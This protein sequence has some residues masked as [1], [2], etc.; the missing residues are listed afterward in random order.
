MK[1]SKKLLWV[2]FVFLVL[3]VI[4]RLSMPSLINYGIVDWFE[5]QGIIA[6]VEKVHI[7]LSN[8]D[9][10][11]T[12][13]TGNK[14][15]EQVLKLEE[16]SISWFW[17]TL[18][19]S[20]AKFRSIKLDG[21]AFDIE[22]KEN[23]NLIVA[24]LDINQLSKSS[25]ETETT[26]ADEDNEPVDWRVILEELKLTD[27]DICYRQ[28]DQ[29]YCNHF[30]KLNW[31]GE[32][33][34]DLSKLDDPALP[35]YA[36]GSFTI[37]ALQVHDNIL[38]RDLANFEQ[39]SIEGI[40]IDSFNSLGLADLNLSDFNFC[41]KQLEQDHCG[42]FDKLGW[43]GNLTVDL[44]NLDGTPP[45]INA[46]GGFGID[47]LKVH[48]NV[49]DRDLAS[50]KQFS[51]EGIDIATLESVGLSGLTLSDFNACYKLP[52]QDYCSHFDNLTWQ[53]DVTANLNNL[54]GSSPPVNAKGKFEINALRVHNNILGKD[55]TN[56]EQLSVE[57]IDIDSL[58]A[59]AF[60]T[61][62]MGPLALLKRN[63]DELAPQVTRFDQ[64][65]LS[66]VTLKSLQQ[67]SIDQI[68]I[69]DHELLLINKADKTL[70]LQEWLP[71]Q[72][73]TPTAAD[74]KPEDKT[75]P[76]QYVIN[77][78]IYKT[79]KSIHYRDNS[80][81]KPFIV[82]LNN[83]LFEVDNLDSSQPEQDSKVHYS[84][85]Y[86]EHGKISL[87]G[88]ARP[89]LEKPSFD[90]SGKISGLDLR[91][92]SPFTSEAIGHSIKS[93]QLDADLKLKAD[94]A[95][96]DSEVDLKL[97]HFEL[98]ALS[99]ED[100]KKINADFGFPLNSSLSL[101]KDGDNTI[102]LSIPVTGDLENPDF[103]AND[104]ITQATS[105]AITSAIISYYTPFG[106]VMAVEGLID[107]ATALDFDPVRF[108]P[109][110]NLLN[111]KNRDDLGKLVQLMN[112]RPGIHLTLCS[113]TNTADRKI[114]LPETAEIALDQLKLEPEQVSKLVQL[115]ES[116]ADG[117]KQYLV[118]QKIE[119]SR[120]VLCA[121]EHTEG[122]GLAGVEI[123]I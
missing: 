74:A 110:D 26:S 84:A 13:I 17:K 60:K 15:G 104:A 90:M 38:G 8:G 21:L 96:L 107:L 117:V 78:F 54:D 50:F 41:F 105:S 39:F 36:N 55:L 46:K 2:A 1:K 27:F 119:A 72:S 106:L 28:S 18:L 23:G 49:L 22:Q 59:I 40:D 51:I 86:A 24:G 12:G 93:G 98:T 97:F 58:D 4:V 62:S 66:D 101:L 45:P 75:T 35:I 47:A 118:E 52:D 114:A 92:I 85:Q 100:E 91:D 25:P 20:E 57:E 63:Q 68:T 6:K 80:L 42:H 30:D 9:F 19:N 120:L 76:F 10:S 71:A 67:L 99:P 116:R 34:I 81:E 44:S 88:T 102:E 16:V 87:D 115:G 61:L 56:L 77:K 43:Q 7:D 31:Q 83:I 109:G 95:V 14:E 5:Q 37:D 103:D 73:E 32:L 79:G 70:E 94:A 3:V 123:S 82:D 89:L 112:E 121:P 48:D 122:E 33:K 64:I 29:D 65:Q 111:D 108:D 113:F 11:L 53:G 69:T